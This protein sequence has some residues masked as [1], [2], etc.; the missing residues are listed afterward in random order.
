MSPAQANGGAVAASPGRGAAL[1][2]AVDMDG[3]L[4]RT[5]MLMEG[6]AHGLFRRP[7]AT[8]AAL[9][10]VLHG[11]A[12]LKS[13]IGEISAG[14]DIATL[15]VN[16]ELLARL[17]QE[18]ARGRELHLV[19]ASDAQVA[20]RVAERFGLFAGVLGSA[21]GRNLKGAAKREALLARFPQGFAYA[22]DSF[23]DLAVWRRAKGVMFAG[24]KR[25]A[26]QQAARLGLPV[27]GVFET[28]GPSFAHWAPILG[29]YSWLL[30]L[31]I[32][33][34]LAA[35]EVSGY[36]S[37]WIA[38]LCAFVLAGAMA[39][40]VRIAFDLSRIETERLG[41]NARCPFATGDIP[42]AHG[43]SAAPVLVLGSLCIS[44]LHSQG[45]VFALA[46]FGLLLWLHHAASAPHR[47]LLD[48][49]AI[50]LG[51]ILRVVMGLMAV[52]AALP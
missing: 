9:P 21:D 26:L 49:L 8:L 2:L 34:P 7:L 22:G 31:L 17:R 25:K 11:R 16:L 33:T 46:A 12:Q 44:V 42:L 39:S 3:T 29:G 6:L 48:T 45:F 43:L 32:F 5:D 4:L 50:G 52:D 23:A 18:R 36:P 41:G 15:P 38:A 35:P 40:G 13:R 47:P 19:T 20:R 24:W 27:E 30:N 10:L 14:L 1:P 28:A 37:A 51:A